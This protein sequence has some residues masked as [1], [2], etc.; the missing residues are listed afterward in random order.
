VVIEVSQNDSFR[1]KGSLPYTFVLNMSQEWLNECS[2]MLL[3]FLGYKKSA[4]KHYSLTSCFSPGIL[5]SGG[6]S[7]SPE[8]LRS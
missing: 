3:L 1:E 7:W 8:N 4:S 5:S 6:S 2:R